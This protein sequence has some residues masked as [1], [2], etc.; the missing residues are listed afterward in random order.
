MET[1][2]KGLKNPQRAP[3]PYPGL[4]I[5]CIMHADNAADLIW[6]HS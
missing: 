5:L 3:L 6:R 1:Y 4:P 2:M